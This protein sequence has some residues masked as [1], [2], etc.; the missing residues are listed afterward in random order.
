MNASMPHRRSIPSRWQRG[1][2]RARNSRRC[3]NL[4]DDAVIII[5]KLAIREKLTA[6]WRVLGLQPINPEVIRIAT[7]IEEFRN[8]FVHFKW[9]SFPD[10]SVEDKTWRAIN[11]VKSVV[12]TLW[13]YEERYVY[14]G[15]RGR[16]ATSAAR[17][18]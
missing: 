12:H 15:Q 17:I 1:K 5:R 8:A 11:Q 7:V 3:C 18:K 9:P 10:L 6:L 4:D 2:G 14:Y 13:D 16:I